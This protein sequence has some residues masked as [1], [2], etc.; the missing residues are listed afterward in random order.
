M[1]G[2]IIVLAFV[3]FL[4]SCIHKNTKKVY[5][6]GR[7]FYTQTRIENTEDTL[8]TYYDENGDIKDWGI[9]KIK[10]GKFNGG[11]YRFSKDGD[12]TSAM[13]CINGKWENTRV[14]FSD[15]G[16]VA[17]ITKFYQGHKVRDIHLIS[18]DVV[19][20]RPN[21]DIVIKNDIGPFVTVDPISDTIILGETYSARI[22]VNF[23]AKGFDCGIYCL[24]KTPGQRTHYANISLSPVCTYTETPREIGEHIYSIG[25]LQTKKSPQNKDSLILNLDNIDFSVKYYVKPRT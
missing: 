19:L 15:S 8:M 20:A 1:S 18:S 12:L 21:K 25:V 24:D 13:Y 9:Y 2:K 22:V 7:L 14:L 17:D 5:R 16:K 10:K 4:V 3:I 6:D 11:V 23:P